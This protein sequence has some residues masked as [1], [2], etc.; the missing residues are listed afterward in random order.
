MPPQN[1]RI[2]P[3][4]ERE[5]Y[6]VSSHGAILFYI[7]ANPDCTSTDIA[8]AMSLTRRTVWSIVGDLRQVGM[9]RVRKEGRRHHY[10][11]NLDAHLQHPLLKDYTLRSI[12]GR[13]VEQVTR[14]TTDE[15]G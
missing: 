10:T 14:L 3:T 7:A 11:V 12:L 9:L 8:R 1:R 6:L 15:A 5:W 4:S 2:T 13:L